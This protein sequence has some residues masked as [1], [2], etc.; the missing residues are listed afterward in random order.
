MW[1][2]VGKKMELT[3][4]AAGIDAVAVHVE[5]AVGDHG[6][7][8]GVPQQHEVWLLPGGRRR[9][10]AAVELLVGTGSEQVAGAEYGSALRLQ[11]L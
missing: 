9:G 6:I 7:E 11:F 8:D 10:D 4:G 3:C 1:K 5:W 2:L